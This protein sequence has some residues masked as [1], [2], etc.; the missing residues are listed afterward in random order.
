MHSFMEVCE[1]ML[2]MH[3]DIVKESGM[4]MHMDLVKESGVR[5]VR[6]LCL[7][8]HMVSEAPIYLAG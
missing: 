7:A 4:H 6:P 1:C 8:C 3:M 5:P 2:H